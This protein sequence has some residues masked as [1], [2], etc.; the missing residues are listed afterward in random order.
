MVAFRMR[1][2]PTAPEREILQIKEEIYDGISFDTLLG[3]IPHVGGSV[4]YGEDYGYGYSRCNHC[5]YCDGNKKAYLVWEEQEDIEDFDKRY[6]DYEKKLAK[7]EIWYEENKERIEERARLEEDK[8]KKTK[9]D[10]IKECEKTIEKKK[11]ELKKLY[12]S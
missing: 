4:S 11:K 2:K 9:E 3:L 12:K 1:R 6:K 5:D 8:K 10:K 7:W